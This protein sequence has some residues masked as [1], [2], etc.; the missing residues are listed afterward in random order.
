M[1]HEKFNLSYYLVLKYLYYLAVWLSDTITAFLDFDSRLEGVFSS[2]ELSH[3]RYGMGDSVF[4][5]LCSYPVLCFM[6]GGPCICLTTGQ[7]RASNCV[8]VLI[9]GLRNIQNPHSA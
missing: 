9:Y 1:I 5:F 6:E 4:H 2:R 7:G 8:R 3:G